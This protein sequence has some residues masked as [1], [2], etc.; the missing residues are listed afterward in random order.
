MLYYEILDV[1]IIELETKRSLSVS[2]MGAHNKEDPHL[3]TFLLPKT[4]TVHELADQLAKQ[5]SLRPDGTH[6]IRVFVSAALGRLQRELHMFDSINSIPEGTE[7]FAE[8]IWPE[9]LALGEDAKLVHMCHFFRDV[10]RVHSVPLR[11][12]LLRNER[13]ADTAKRIQARLDVPDKEFA[14]F[15]FALIQTS[16]YKQPTYLEDDDVVFDHKFLPDDVIGIDHMDRSGRASRLYGLHP[17]DR[18][19]QIRS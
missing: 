13:F 8:E 18:G 17:Q 11:F 19:I 4:A 6:K 12:V 16:Q 2:W 9:E 7:L 15:R 1:S 14:K 5:V 10:A 3:Y